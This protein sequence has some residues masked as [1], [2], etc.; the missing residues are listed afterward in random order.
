MIGGPFLARNAWIVAQRK[1]KT[2][3]NDHRKLRRSGHRC[4]RKATGDR[5][6]YSRSEQPATTGWHYRAREGTFGPFPSRE[7]A[8]SDLKALIAKS[9]GAP[10]ERYRKLWLKLKDSG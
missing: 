3:M 1:R 9:R 10:R 6:F 8:E 2:R 4:D 5:V 7:A